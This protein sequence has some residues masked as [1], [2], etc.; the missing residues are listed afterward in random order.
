MKPQKKVIILAF[1]LSFFF[2]FDNK[3]ML[4][5]LENKSQKKIDSIIISNGYDEIKIKNLY[6]NKTRKVY[7]KF[8]KQKP[9]SDGSFF[10]KVFPN[11][12]RKNFGYYSSGI[13]P[14][15][16]YNILLKDDTISIKEFWNH[17]K[18][19]NLTNAL[20]TYYHSTTKN[21]PQ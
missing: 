16:S 21:C 1:F 17:N 11:N 10:I 14:S 12:L 20:N 2:S 7:L 8:V 18:K 5:E 3:G 9:K 6:K 13:V 15:Y 19:T 4:F